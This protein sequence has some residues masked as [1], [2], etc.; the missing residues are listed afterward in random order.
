MD[1]GGTG[2]EQPPG[3]DEVSPASGAQ[4]DGDEEFPARVSAQDRQAFAQA[5]A[6]EVFDRH[7]GEVYQYVLAW[8]GDSAIAYDLTAKVLR[9]AVARMEHLADPETDLEVRLIALARAAVAGRSEAPESDAGTRK[10]GAFAASEPVPFLLGAVAHLDDTRRD[11]VILRHLLG[12]STEHTARLLAFDPSVVE[13]LERDACASLW[14][15]VNRAP[16]TKSVTTWEALSVGAALRQG[17]STWLAPPDSAVMGRLREQFLGDLDPDRKRVAAAAPA[18]ER[19]RLLSDL[20]DLALRR[21]WLV[22]GCV[23]SAAIGIVVALVMGGPP[24]RPSPCGPPTCLVST[25][26]GSVA[27]TGVS[28]PPQAEQPGALPSSSTRTGRGSGP[29]VTSGGSVTSGPVATTTTLRGTKPAPS[30]TRPRQPTTTT[31]PAPTSMT[32]APTTTATLPTTSTS[33]TP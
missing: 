10:A 18:G 8:T 33:G 31:N 22:A 7:A 1:E 28:S 25:T 9:G 30:T 15:R 23:G 6:E 26:A 29:V 14:R 27:D 5:F 20:A 32:T 13:E 19:W 16:Q 17:A 21:R 3:I 12:R 24:G 2:A 4:M 11:V